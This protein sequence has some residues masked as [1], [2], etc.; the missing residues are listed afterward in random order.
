MKDKMRLIATLL[1]LII[2]FLIA[3]AIVGMI[4]EG[5]PG[6]FYSQEVKLHL[7]ETERIKDVPYFLF[8]DPEVE[9]SINER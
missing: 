9:V 1:I 8:E 7:T 2:V 5:T 4:P 3:L 6:I